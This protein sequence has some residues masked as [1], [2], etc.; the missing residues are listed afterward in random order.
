MVVTG[1]YQCEVCKKI[2]RIRVQL[3]W[4]NTYPIRIKCGECS[5]PIYGEVE[6]QPLQG[7]YNIE[8]NNVKITDSNKQP[9]FIIEVSGELLTE[10][11]EK[12]TDSKDNLFSPFFKNALWT[13]GDDNLT[14]FKRDLI[15]F[16]ND[17]KVKWPV[18]RR[19]NELWLNGNHKYLK[20]EIH[21][22][23]N[24]T[25][26]PADNE[27]EYLRAVHGINIRFF[28]PITKWHFKNSTDLIF[29]VIKEV[30]EK[31]PENYKELVL[32]FELKLNAYEQKIYVIM[33]NFIEKFP[34]VLPI[35]GL[36]Y[37]EEQYKN[38]AI[39]KLGLTT[40][41]FEDI[42]DFYIETFEDIIEIFDLIIAYENLL[43]RNDFTVMDYTIND[44][45]KTLND[46]QTKMKN[47]GKKLE[48]INSLERLDEILHTKIDNKLRN[49]IGHRS[50]EYEVESQKIIYFSSGIV[51]KGN[52]EEIYLN[53]F[54]I[55]CLDLFRTAL[56]VGEIVYQTRKNL[57]VFKGCKIRSV[58]D[59]Y[60]KTG[61]SNKK[62]I[63]YH[64]EKI[65]MK[66]RKKKNKLKAQKEARK[67]N[68]RSK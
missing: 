25:E 60:P 1:D 15:S 16:I 28:S 8:L 59:Y 18:A 49:A 52:Q 48:F 47:K 55:K 39:K 13:M 17:I 4:L 42:K 14:L 62:N 2:T 68:R 29:K 11:L 61:N 45:I 35:L 57:L 26:Y 23:F 50:Y 51:G 33:C 3:G 5:I 44:Q 6:L 30:I 53:E 54:V 24:K 46:F 32:D 34:M 22:V 20:N 38:E 21:K 37:Y 12:F 64:S 66:Y 9:D 31:K 58:T 56:N 65:N 36:E 10:K 19:I 63:K 40:V 27:L 43:L 67:I 41:N 7:T